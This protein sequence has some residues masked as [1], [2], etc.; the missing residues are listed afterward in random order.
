MFCLELIL[1]VIHHLLKNHSI[2]GNQSWNLGHKSN[3]CI[4]LSITPKLLV[5][6][7]INIF[8]IKARIWF[9]FLLFWNLYFPLWSWFL[10]IKW[11]V[12]IV[13]LASVLLENLTPLGFAPELFQPPFMCLGF[14]QWHIKLPW[15][16]ILQ[17]DQSLSTSTFELVFN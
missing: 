17:N 5:S 1:K 16:V 7:Q 11:L 14:S 15:V 13:R 3:I 2:Q 8:H 12:R 6:L 10:E 4:N 9:L